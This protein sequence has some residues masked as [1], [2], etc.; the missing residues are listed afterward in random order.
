[1]ITVS[2]AGKNLVPRTAFDDAA[3]MILH[4][5][6]VAEHRTL[7]EGGD[8]A[9]TLSSGTA[10][11]A[12][13][14]RSVASGGYGHPYGF[15]K[16]GA[17]GVRGPIPNGGDPAKINIQTGEF[18]EGWEELVGF[19]KG[20]E[21]VNSIVNETEHAK[22]IEATP[23]EFQI[24]RPVIDALASRIDVARQQNLNKALEEINNL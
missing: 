7:A 4:E 24:R 5:I 10:T 1:M 18:A 19:F 13:L 11:E 14:S 2:V 12:M 9:H 8:I 16:S 21:M 22:L 20:D 15:G 6:E 23:T 3:I 17:A